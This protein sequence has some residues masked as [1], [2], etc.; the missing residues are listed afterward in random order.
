MARWWWNLSTSLL[1][2]RFTR[3]HLTCFSWYMIYFFILSCWNISSH[4]KPET[5]FWAVYWHLLTLK[6]GHMGPWSYWNMS[7]PVLDFYLLASKNISL[8]GFH[9]AGNSINEAELNTVE[10]GY[11]EF[12]PSRLNTFFWKNHTRHWILYWPLL[13]ITIGK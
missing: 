4:S 11:L 12:V 2:I 5:Y 8:L 10:L 1:E 13:T 7:I 6:V 3:S 9:L